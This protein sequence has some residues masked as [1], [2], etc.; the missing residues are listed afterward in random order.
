MKLKDEQMAVSQQNIQ[1]RE[2]NGR[3]QLLQARQRTQEVLNELES[4]RSA[5]VTKTAECEAQKSAVDAA[6]YTAASIQE[7]NATLKLE[8]EQL[9]SSLQSE[10][11][12]NQERKKKVRDFIN[13]AATE[14]SALETRIKELEG[15]LAEASAEICS[16][17][18][19]VAVLNQVTHPL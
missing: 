19:S 14:K 3:Q 13:T 16:A 4:V 1:E 2:L 9:N 18:E 8:I 7:K 15:R 6:N 10:I 17:N 11:S 12:Q 5:L